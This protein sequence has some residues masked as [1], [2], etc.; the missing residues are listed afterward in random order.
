MVRAEKES[1]EKCDLLGVAPL[2]APS[3]ADS[4]PGGSA[5]Q[6]PLSPPVGTPGPRLL[7]PELGLGQA[8]GADAAVL[9]TEPGT[10]GCRR[11]G[12]GGG[13]GGYWAGTSSV[14]KVSR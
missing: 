4:L 10:R 1:K 14:G 3:K 7:A 2:D 9:G 13:S 6:P 5:R 12:I 8:G 11:W